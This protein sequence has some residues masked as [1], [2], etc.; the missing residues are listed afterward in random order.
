MNIYQELIQDLNK[1][2][3]K[4]VDDFLFRISMNSDLDR[5]QKYGSTRIGLSSKIWNKSE[6][7]SRDLFP[8][9]PVLHQDMIIASYWKDLE[10]DVL[11]ENGTLKDKLRIYDKPFFTIYIK[12]KLLEIGKEDSLGHNNQGTHFFFLDKPINCLDSLWQINKNN[13]N[14]YVEE[15]KWK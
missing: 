5:V 1:K 2:F 4:N 10:D 15:L 9:Y 6:N 8:K 11:L 3:N 14:Y 12:S 7:Y 13:N